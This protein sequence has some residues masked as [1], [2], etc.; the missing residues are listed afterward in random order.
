MSKFDK[1][2]ELLIQEYGLKR[3]NEKG[4]SMIPSDNGVINWINAVKKHLT[5]NQSKQQALYEAT[6]EVFGNFLFQ[7]EKQI[8][9]K[10]SNTQSTMILLQ[11][12]E[13]IIKTEN[14]NT[15]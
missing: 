6:K 1:L 3:K 15:F 11:E 13:S 14:A 4:E 2:K 10:N 5:L 12:L 8:Y 9:V 7:E